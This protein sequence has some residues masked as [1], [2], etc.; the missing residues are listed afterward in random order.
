MCFKIGFPCF[1]TRGIGY[2]SLL[3]FYVYLLITSY[4][5]IGGCYVYISM[6]LDMAK[7]YID[8]RFRTKNSKSESD[9]SFELPRSFNIPDGVI[10]HIDVIVLP[11]SWS[12]IHEINHDCF[13]NVTCNTEVLEGVFSFDS[14]NYDGG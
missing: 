12:T 11:I 7:N 4:K 3:C 2:Q 8:T 10:A 9:F 1:D 14:K 5:Q 6:K 13:I